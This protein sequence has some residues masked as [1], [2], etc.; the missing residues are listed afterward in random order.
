[1]HFEE[2]YLFIYR[3]KKDLCEGKVRTLDKKDTVRALF[4]VKVIVTSYHYFILLV[5]QLLRF[6]A[7]N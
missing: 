5:S 3:V 4:K 7:H 1:M 6:S 2:I